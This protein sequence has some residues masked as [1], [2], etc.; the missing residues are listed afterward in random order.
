MADDYIFNVY[1]LTGMRDQLEV[2]ANYSNLSADVTIDSRSGKNC[3]VDWQN[4]HE[5]LEYQMTELG[6]T[7]SYNV[8]TGEYITNLSG[9]NKLSCSDNIDENL[10]SAYSDLL[11]A[12]TDT[13]REMVT[14]ENRNLFIFDEIED[15]RPVIESL[16]MIDRRIEIYCIT[17]TSVSATSVSSRLSAFE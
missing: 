2:N 10:E 9:E 14:L 1:R 13:E 8:I 16:D 17:G 12:V 6:H 3:F 5:D 4:H 7:T 11:S 15:V